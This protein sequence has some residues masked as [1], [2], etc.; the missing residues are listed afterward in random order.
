VA[1]AVPELAV[2][3]VMND[4]E[5]ALNRSSPVDLALPLARRGRGFDRH[6]ASALT[7]C[8]STALPRR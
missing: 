2:V 8:V 7:P 3:A 4:L 1:D 5:W 6:P